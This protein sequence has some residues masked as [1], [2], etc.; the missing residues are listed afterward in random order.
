[1]ATPSAYRQP[2]SALG[3]VS[4]AVAAPARCCSCCVPMV[5]WDGPCPSPCWFLWLHRECGSKAV[6]AFS[7]CTAVV[8]LCSSAVLF[9]GISPFSNGA[10]TSRQRLVP[11][12]EIQPYFVPAYLCNPV[13]Y[14][15]WTKKMLRPALLFHLPYFSITLLAVFTFI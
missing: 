6:C 13:V 2:F 1:M 4:Q 3:W 5:W 10:T 14:L 9:L 11:S 15:K 12:I 7:H 8:L